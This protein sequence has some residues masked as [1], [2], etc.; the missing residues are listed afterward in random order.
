MR[1]RSRLGR[2]DRGVNAH[3]IRAFLSALKEKAAAQ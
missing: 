2:I 1:S 3:R